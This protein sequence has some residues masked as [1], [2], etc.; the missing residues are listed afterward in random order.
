MLVVSEDN[1]HNAWSLVPEYRWEGEAIWAKFSR[2]HDGT[3]WYYRTIADALNEADSPAP[4][5]DMR[6]QLEQHVVYVRS[7]WRSHPLC[8]LG[9]ASRKS[10]KPSSPFS[11]IV[12]D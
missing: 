6:Y 8:S 12:G 1:L 10:S 11:H 4:I 3:L 9:R 7:W 5:V 2:G